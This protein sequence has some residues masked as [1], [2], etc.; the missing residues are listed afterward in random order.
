LEMS[1]IPFMM[2]NTLLGNIGNVL[3]PCYEGQNSSWIYW[4]CPSSPL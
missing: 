4:K 1:F 2:D 3:H